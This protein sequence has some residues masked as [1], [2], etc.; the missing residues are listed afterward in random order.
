MPFSESKHN[1]IQKETLNTLT[2]DSPH[3]IHTQE[4]H[5]RMVRKHGKPAVA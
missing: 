4:K 2:E 3:Q 5:M 1:K